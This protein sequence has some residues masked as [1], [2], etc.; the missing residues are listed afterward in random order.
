M[1]RCVC[2]QEVWIALQAIQDGR[3][4]EAAHG[5]KHPWTPTGDDAL[6][7]AQACLPR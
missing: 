4:Q 1:P 2:A 7:K 5:D 6:D 3:L